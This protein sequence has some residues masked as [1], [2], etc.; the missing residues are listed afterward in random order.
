MVTF[1]QM[2]TVPY[3]WMVQRPQQ[4]MKQLSLKGHTVYYIESKQGNYIKKE[5]NNLNIIG[6]NYNITSKYLN[7][8]IIL[9]CSSP[10]QVSNIDKIP[11]DYVIYDVVDDATHE[12]SSWSGHINSML[13][14]ANIVFTSS[15][16]LYDK[17]KGMH[18]KVYLINNGV[19]LDNFSKSKTFT[20]RDLPKNKKIV[21]YV[22]AVASWLDWNLINHIVKDSNY[23]FVFVGPLYNINNFPIL[24]SN[25]YF[26]GVKNYEYIPYYINNFNCCIIPFQINSMTNACNPIKLY[27]YMSSGKPIVSTAMKE[28]VNFSNLCY[29]ANSKDSF[30]KHI[31]LAINE[32][33]KNLINLRIKTA[34]NNSWSSRTNKILDILKKELKI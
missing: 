21:G 19:D 13:S 2:P 3:N 32:N 34:E 4:I 6:A 14:R 18:N 5:N 11:H 25:V 1:I 16:Q 29:I 7:R 27:E 30:K 10:D 20:P 33:D 26:L 12:F 28:V 15:K 31:N 24:R 17:F 23:N 9:W 8:P 22:G